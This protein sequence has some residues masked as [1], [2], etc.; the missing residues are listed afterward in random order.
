MK[1]TLLQH[2]IASRSLVGVAVALTLFLYLA[3]GL[4]P[5]ITPILLLS[6][7]VILR[8]YVHMRKVKEDVKITPKETTNIVYYAMLALLG[9]VVGGM[10]IEGLYIPPVPTALTSLALTMPLVLTAFTFLM[11]ISEELF[12]RGEMFDLV[13]SRSKF[14]IST[15]IILSAV[16]FTLYHLFV[17]ARDTESLAYVFVGGTMLSWSAWKTHRLLTPMVAH[18]LNNFGGLPFLT[19][20]LI[21]VAILIAVLF[22]RR[23]RRQVSW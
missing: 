2:D 4:E 7:A 9:M 12:F 11:V 19:P 3:V 8:V 14:A 18:L 10:F 17:Y 5:L 13:A 1:I 20:I 21:V 6:G 23:K 22:I 16:L 15:A